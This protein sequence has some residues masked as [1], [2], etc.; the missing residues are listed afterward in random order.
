MTKE[1]SKVIHVRN[2]GHEISEDSQPN[3]VL[4]VTF[5]HQL[6]PITDEV[7]HQVFSPHG[8]VEKIV[9]FQEAAGL[10]V[11][12]QYQDCQ[13]AT[14]AR[15]MLQSIFCW[16]TV[17]GPQH[18]QPSRIL[19]V[20]IHYLDYPITEEVLHQ[21][22]SPHGFVEKIV[23]FQM[24][25]DLILLVTMKILQYLLLIALGFNVVA[26]LM[27]DFTLISSTTLAKVLF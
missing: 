15:T 3:Q 14:R 21:V 20:T 26:T 27:Q 6:Y 9:T 16:Y 12:I 22:F 7:L 25:T 23:T 11:L 1:P 24:E 8:F 5:H 19:L 2:V 4:L 17:D 18:S 10:Q 13:S